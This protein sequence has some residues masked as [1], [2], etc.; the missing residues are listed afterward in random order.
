MADGDR[1]PPREL[2]LGFCRHTPVV[3]SDG[4]A[5][6]NAAVKGVGFIPC[7]DYIEAVTQ[8]YLAHIGQGSTENYSR[9][10]LRL[11]A[12]VLYG[13]GCADVLDFSLL[14]SLELAKGR[15]WQNLQATR[16]AVLL[17]YEPPVTSFEVRTRVAIHAEGSPYHTLINAQHDVYHGPGRE[18]WP[19]CPAYVFHIESVRNKAP[20]P[21]G[22]GA[23]LT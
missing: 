18:R 22:W 8:R 19:E 4:P 20:K 6:L 10:G 16:Q 14:G 17:F 11:L 21:N 9:D 7:S 13:D 5:G 2:F 12:D 3:C 15:T 23:P 1:V